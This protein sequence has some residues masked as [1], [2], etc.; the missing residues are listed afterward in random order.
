MINLRVEIELFSKEHS[1]LTKIMYAYNYIYMGSIHQETSS[2]HK[3]IT[4]TRTIIKEN[5]RLN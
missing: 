3:L 1:Q 4:R 2:N 5:A